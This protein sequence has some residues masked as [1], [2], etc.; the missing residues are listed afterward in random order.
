MHLVS[1]D[2]IM[3]EARNL[4]NMTI[5]QTPLMGNENTPLHPADGGTGFEGATP[6]HQVAFTPN[7]LAM[8]LHSGAVDGKLAV[9]AMPLRTP[10]RDNL[11][12]YGDWWGNTTKAVT[13]H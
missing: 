6:R 9:G 4:R 5:A 10:I 3:A 2:N 11:N 1:E 8:P 7:P 13:P 12:W